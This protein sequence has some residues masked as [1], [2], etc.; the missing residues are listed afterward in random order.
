MYGLVTHTTAASAFTNRHAAGAQL[1]ERELWE[2]FIVAERIDG[3][4]AC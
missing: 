3:R 4:G 2:R 1:R